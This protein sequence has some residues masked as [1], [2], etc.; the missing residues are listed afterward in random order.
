MKIIS[1]N[2]VTNIDYLYI[3]QAI[4]CKKNI[5]PDK[6]KEDEKDKENPNKHCGK[7]NYCRFCDYNIYTCNEQDDKK[8]LM[9][10]ESRLKAALF[11]EPN[12]DNSCSM[13]DEEENCGGCG[14]F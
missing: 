12:L 6:E 1:S 7:Y 2:L 14:H 8:S 5:T 11:N 4:N 9:L 3:T 13:K 10:L